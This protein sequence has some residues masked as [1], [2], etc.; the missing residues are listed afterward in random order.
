M[1][2]SAAFVFVPSVRWSIAIP[3]GVVCEAHES[4]LTVLVDRDSKLRIVHETL[5]CANES[6]FYPIKIH[7]VSRLPS[8]S[9]MRKGIADG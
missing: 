4:L 5:L 9:S 2:F 3:S 8:Y 6:D 7:I 1:S